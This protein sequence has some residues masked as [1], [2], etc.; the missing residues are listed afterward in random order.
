MEFR[1]LIE[2][3]GEQVALY[4]AFIWALEEGVPYYDAHCEHCNSRQQAY[5]RYGSR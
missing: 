1:S 5:P 3:Y 2:G 4:Q